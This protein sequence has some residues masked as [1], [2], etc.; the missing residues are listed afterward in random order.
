MK[1]IWFFV[2]LILLIMGIAVLLEGVYLFY[3]PPLRQTVLAGTH[4]NFWWG[5]IM[6]ASGGAFVLKNHKAKM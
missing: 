6:I 3:N 1:P 2:G 4:P 5:S